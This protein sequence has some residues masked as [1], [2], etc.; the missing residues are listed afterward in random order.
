MSAP[1]PAGA[2]TGVPAVTP[3]VKPQGLP[4]QR[5]LLAEANIEAATALEGEARLP[6]V[7][8]ELLVAR[9]VKNARE[10]HAF[11]NP[12][13]TDLHDPFLM[14]GMSAA[15][16]RLERAIAQRERLPLT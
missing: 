11:L 13:I 8:A 15:V 2:A 10:A 14:L 16:E 7:V 6:H 3:A 12:E 9:G 4:P 5:W 1:G